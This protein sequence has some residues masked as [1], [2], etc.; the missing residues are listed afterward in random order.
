MADTADGKAICII[1]GELVAYL[2]AIDIA[3][4]DPNLNRFTA[5]TYL[6]SYIGRDL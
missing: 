2:Q 3:V 5:I 6:L 4:C 1:Q